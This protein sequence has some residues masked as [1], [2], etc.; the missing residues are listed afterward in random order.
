MSGSS[1]RPIRSDRSQA[2]VIAAKRR[3]AIGVADG[4]VGERPEAVVEDVLRDGEI[5]RPET[6]RREKH[7][8]GG[9]TAHGGETV[10]VP[11]IPRSRERRRPGKPTSMVC[12][13][14]PSYGPCL[15]SLP[16]PRLAS[17]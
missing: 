10:T 8:I 7:Q 13:C 15:P 6:D 2:S 5:E 3:A 16:A 1:R 9:R 4:R 11:H 14:A 17:G 12:P